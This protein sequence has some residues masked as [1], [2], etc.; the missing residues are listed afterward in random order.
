MPLDRVQASKGR[1]IVPKWYHGNSANQK[2][3]FFTQCRIL[4]IISHPVSKDRQWN[5]VVEC[6]TNDQ[7][8]TPARDNAISFMCKAR[9]S[10]MAAKNWQVP[11]TWRRKPS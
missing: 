11:Q 3:R 4:S 6:Y 9:G 5:P 10:C 8:S 2:K 1:R 7:G